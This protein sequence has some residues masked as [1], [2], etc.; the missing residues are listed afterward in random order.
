M[1]IPTEPRTLDRML[2]A[3]IALGLFVAPH[4]FAQTT[5]PRTSTDEP[6]ERGLHK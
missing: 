5:S 6:E 4:L 2:A 1:K 3:S